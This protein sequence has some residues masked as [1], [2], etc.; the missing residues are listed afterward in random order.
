MI[1]LIIGDKFQ[2]G[3]KSRGCQATLPY[4]KIHNYIQHQHKILSSGDINKVLYIYG[5]NN[6]K[7]QA[8]LQAVNNLN[9]IT[10][11]YNPQFELKNDT[12]S[13]YLAREEI[14]KV[15]DDLLIFFG[16]TS[17]DRKQLN[18]IEHNVSG[19]FADNQRLSDIGCICD[20]GKVE[21]VGFDLDNS[22]QNI[23][24]ICKSDLNYFMKIVGNSQNHNRFIFEIINQMID[25]N[26]T[27]KLY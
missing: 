3:M 9:N 23:Y 13:I 25:N 1:A 21:N 15:S 16:N 12:Y 26:I 19:L 8:Y 18:K 2:K 5:F 24:Y 11:I 7:Y 14:T 17:L 27:F 22:I 10:S 6:K 20:D 4:N